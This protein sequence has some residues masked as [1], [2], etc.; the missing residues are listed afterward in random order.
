MALLSPMNPL[1]GG[2]IWTLAVTNAIWVGAAALK[3]ASE[4]AVASFIQEIVIC[5]FCIRKQI[6]SYN[7]TPFLNLMWAN[8]VKNTD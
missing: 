7:G 3:R 4:A 6:L 8:Y 1:S 2:H 5:K